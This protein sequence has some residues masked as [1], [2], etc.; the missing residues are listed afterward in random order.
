MTK[1]ERFLRLLGLRLLQRI[2]TRMIAK[3]KSSSKN[4]QAEKK[5]SIKGTR[6]SRYVPPP[7]HG[8][9]ATRKRR[10][11]KSGTARNT[12]NRRKG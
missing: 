2:I 11:A 6:G 1:C 9:T 5:A 10:V 7:A 3:L 12:S 4:E 8:K